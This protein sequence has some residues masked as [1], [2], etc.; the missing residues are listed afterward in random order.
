M[1]R[2]S[3]GTAI[4]DRIQE[5][6][7]GQQDKALLPNGHETSSDND[8]MDYE[9]EDDDDDEDVYYYDDED[10]NDDEY[11]DSDGRNC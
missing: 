4:R 3:Q 2:F 6:L 10:F 9:E 11:Y 7:R 5:S 1:C 8:D